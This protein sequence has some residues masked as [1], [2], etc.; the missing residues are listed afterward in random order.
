MILKLYYT[1]FS[2]YLWGKLKEMLL[3]RADDMTNLDKEVMR[4]YPGNDFHLYTIHYAEILKFHLKGRDI[5]II[6][7]AN[8][9][10]FDV[11][12]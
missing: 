1:K 4:S 3:F 7:D 5:E 2:S 12:K 6:N 9:Y 10:K 8:W 11:H